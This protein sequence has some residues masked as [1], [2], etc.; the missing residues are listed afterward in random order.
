MTDAAAHANPTEAL[1]LDRAL[2][3]FAQKGYAATS[4]REIIEAAQV[5]RPVLYYYCDSKEGLF[6][7]IVE[8]ALRDA[9]LG[10]GAVLTQHATCA[11]RLRAI[12]RGS[13]AFCA[14]DPRVP[15]LMF[16]VFSG[17]QTDR[18][19]AIVAH[20]TALRFGV[21]VQTMADGLRRGEIQGGDA[22]SLALAFCCLMDQHINV[23]SQ[24]PE[25]EKRLTPE[26]ADALVDLLL[27]GAGSGERK[28]FRL[29]AFAGGNSHP[30]E[31]S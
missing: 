28:P 3:L 1:L 21:V 22:E 10:L 17:P 29:P 30:G 6:L 5:T 14:R 25:P 12:I 8:T 26:L 15:R 20:L 9:Y 13:F 2:T 4:V 24:L 16:Q 11:D 7:R 27:Y 19:A 18:A 31:S 23:L